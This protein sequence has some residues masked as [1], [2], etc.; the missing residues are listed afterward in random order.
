MVSYNQ[1][2][3]L[4]NSFKSSET[5]INISH[6]YDLY[7]VIPPIA[8]NIMALGPHATA[9]ENNYNGRP[10]AS[11]DLLSPTWMNGLHST[12]GTKENHSHFWGKDPLILSTVSSPGDFNTGVGAGLFISTILPALELAEQEIIFVTCFWTRPVAI[13]HL[14]S[15]LVNLSQKGLRQPPGT[16]K[17]RVR[18]CLSSRSLSQKL[19]HTSSPS[20]YVYPPS[21]WFSKLGLPPPHVLEGI[22]LQVKSIFI[23]PFSVMHPKFAIIDRQR[24][25]LPSCNVSHEIWF[26]CCMSFT[27]PV[28]SCLF[29]FWRAFWGQGKFSPMEL[30]VPSKTLLNP[31]VRTVLLPSPHHRFPSFRPFLSPPVP[32]PTPLNTMLLHLL[33]SAKVS[34]TFLTPN[35]TSP[36]LLSAITTALSNGIS[37]T[38]ITNRRMMLAEQVLTAG[39]ITELCIWRL[40]RQHRAL[41]KA[42]AR[43]Q[44]RTNGEAAHPTVG[45]L[46]VGYI[47]SD[48]EAGGMK[49]IHVKCTIVDGEVVV[50]GS[51]NMDRASWFTSQELGVAVQDEQ[52]ARDVWGKLELGLE[53]RVERYF[54]W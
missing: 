44:A 6:D 50:L 47:I 35:L 15:A 22:D 37:I 49:K 45:K 27:G 43:S 36:P 40:L 8:S 18:I 46:R 19:F 54:G 12:E 31:S 48:P 13:L 39:T 28:V 24:A 11:T 29:Q 41:T 21:Q 16:P 2:Y 20:G 53:G 4:R 10:T 32:P 42:R 25:L 14:S 7:T 33:S 9:P 52:I 26:E 51:G 3:R 30:D 23:L 17:L 34:I 38:V 1:P 5:T